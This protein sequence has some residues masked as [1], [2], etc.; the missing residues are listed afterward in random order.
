MIF[1]ENVCF[2]VCPDSKSDR[3]LLSVSGDD[4]IYSWFVLLFR[5]TMSTFFFD[6]KFTQIFSN[7]ER[8][9]FWRLFK[10]TYAFLYLKSLYNFALYCFNST[11]LFSFC[12]GSKVYSFFYL[13][14]KIFHLSFF[15]EF[16]SSIFFP[17]K[18]GCFHYVEVV[19]QTTVIPIV[20]SVA[21]CFFF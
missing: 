4:L 11:K 15:T 21:V 2:T 9:K 14:Y 12:C 1:L 19:S 17:E 18:E 6:R 5:I 8:K 3:N 10:P 13:P 16:Q 20:L 7:C